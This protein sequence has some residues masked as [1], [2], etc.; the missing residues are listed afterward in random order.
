MRLMIPAVA[1]P[2]TSYKKTDDDADDESSDFI[3]K[4]NRVSSGP[5]Y[6]AKDEDAAIAICH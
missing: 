2:K 5:I 6:A 4:W 3:S 1:E